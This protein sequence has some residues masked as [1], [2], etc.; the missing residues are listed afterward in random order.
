M[1]QGFLLGREDP[2]V[3]ALTSRIA[4]WKECLEYISKRP[5]IGYG[6]NSFWTPRNIREIS[7][8]LGWG[9]GVG[10][11]AYLELILNVGCIGMV[12][13]FLIFSLGIKKS[14]KYL[15]VSKNILYAFICALL[16]FCLLEGILESMM[17][18]PSFLTFL[19]MVALSHLGFQH[20]HRYKEYS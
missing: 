4:L 16:V 18:Y 8:V 5:F 1:R 7:D 14:V 13:F 3:G 10:H 2:S 6:Y 12:T 19:S 11:S 20:P 17:I 9:V 15:K